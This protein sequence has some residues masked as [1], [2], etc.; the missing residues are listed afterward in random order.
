MVDVAKFYILSQYHF[1]NMWLNI[2]M[3]QNY[4]QTWILAKG[5]GNASLLFPCKTFI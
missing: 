3:K 5:I 4:D 2:V 1:G